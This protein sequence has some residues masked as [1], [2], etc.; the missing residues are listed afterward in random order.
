M[1]SRKP[2]IWPEGP[3]RLHG[4]GVPARGRDR[5]RSQ[6]RQHVTPKLPLRRAVSSGEG[7]RVVG[8]AV[9]YRAELQNTCSCRAISSNSTAK[10]LARGRCLSG[11]ASLRIAGECELTLAVRAITREPGAARSSRRLAA[12]RSRVSLE[13]RRCAVHIRR[14]DKTKRLGSALQTLAK[15]TNHEAALDG[16]PDW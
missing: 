5:P 9:D 6:H 15:S 3:A 16:L 12:C 14:P 2:A 1:H 13:V 8:G 7:G 4:V 10:P 11:G